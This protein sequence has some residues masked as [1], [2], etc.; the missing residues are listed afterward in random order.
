MNQQRN[1]GYVFFYVVAGLFA[2]ASGLFFWAANTQKA[3]Q[4]AA[5]QPPTQ[6]IVSKAI[7]DIREGDVVLTRDETG[8]ITDYRRVV[9]T[10]ERMSDHL[11]VLWFEDEQGER[12]KIE[13]TNEHPFWIENKQQWLEAVDIEVGDT[14][15]SPKGEIQTVVK[16]TYES[17]P[18]G[19][20]V[21][22]FEVEGFHTYFVHAKGTRAPPI[23]THNMC[24]PKGLPAVKKAINSGIVHAGDQAVTKG[25]VDAAGRSGVIAELKELSKS[26]TRNGFPSGTLPDP[27]KATSAISR[28]DSVLVPFRDGAA[29]FEVGKNGTARLRTLLNAAELADAIKRLGL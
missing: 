20:P 7:Q 21:Y 26:I 14:V 13:T 4:A 8:Q 2:V 1:F 28:A 22:N 24:A 11:R 10:Y 5:Q 23:W 25:I 18:E 27:G 9:Q 29:V 16:S 19:V 15:T 17:H 6:R 3:A 12:Q